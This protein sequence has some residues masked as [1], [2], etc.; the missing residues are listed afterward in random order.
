MQIE[1][2]NFPIIK[3]SNLR[4]RHLVNG[5]SNQWY[6]PNHSP[7]LDKRNFFSLWFFHLLKAFHKIYSNAT[8]RDTFVDV[9]AEGFR[10]IND[11]FISVRGLQASIDQTRI[12]PCP[13]FHKNF[14]LASMIYHF[15][16]Y[17]SW[18]FVL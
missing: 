14:I 3:V 13:C 15:N 17:H 6:N 8:Q 12:K 10:Q 2:T 16:T 1:L 4:L 18:Q 5:E 7:L 11:S 9:Q